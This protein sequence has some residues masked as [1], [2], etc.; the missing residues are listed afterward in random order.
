MEIQRLGLQN[1]REEWGE[2]EGGSAAVVVVVEVDAE[3]CTERYVHRLVLRPYVPAVL[4]K[5]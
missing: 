5:I 3:H 1:V 4:Q 2:G